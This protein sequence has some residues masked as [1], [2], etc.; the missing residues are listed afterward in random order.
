MK[1]SRII[2]ALFLAVIPTI[3]AIGC[4]VEEQRNDQTSNSKV[5]LQLLFEHD[6]CKV[7]RFWDFGDPVYYTNCRGD[8]RVSM[9]WQHQEDKHT[10]LLQSVTVTK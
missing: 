9:Q 7:Y 1:R 6:G 2:A 3:F 10:R 5:K 8:N 4:A